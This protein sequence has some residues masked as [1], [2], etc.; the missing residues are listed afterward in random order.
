[1]QY[2]ELRECWKVLLYYLD[3]KSLCKLC[4]CNNLFKTIVEA[5]VNYHKVI[6]SSQFN[7]GRIY[8]LSIHNKINN[9][10]TEQMLVSRL[11]LT[12]LLNY[13][14][15]T[16]A[17]NIKY[18]KFYIG[19][20]IQFIQI[21]SDILIPSQ[22][23][24]PTKNDY[25]NSVIAKFVDLAHSIKTNLILPKPGD[26][27]YHIHCICHEFIAGSK[28][29]KCGYTQLEFCKPSPCQDLDAKRLT[30]GIKKTISENVHYL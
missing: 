30:I 23:F 2:F 5:N 10:T 17:G 16:Y 22:F 3:G 26:C 4:Q 6:L 1:M 13:K 7:Q 20:C 18:D 8:E 15:P 14:C 24:K 19:R 21:Q 25:W 29:C 28:T 12:Y 27:Y 11:Y 9:F